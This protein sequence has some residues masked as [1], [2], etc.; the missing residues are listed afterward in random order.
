MDV[1]D[2]YR[3]QLL[4]RTNACVRACVRTHARAR[5]RVSAQRVRTANCVQQRLQT[6]GWLGT[7][8]FAKQILENVLLTFFFSLKNYINICFRQCLCV[9]AL[10]FFRTIAE[11]RLDEN[12]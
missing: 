5:A 3:A 2:L 9:C 12:R 7:F 10:R 4:N 11:K 6:S 1:R 8:G